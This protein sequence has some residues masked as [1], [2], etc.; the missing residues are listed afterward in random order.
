VR[1]TAA[2][3]E[4]AAL[5]GAEPGTVDELLDAATEVIC[6]TVADACVLRLADAPP[7]RHALTPGEAVLL[8]SVESGVISPGAAWTATLFGGAP[9]AAALVVPLRALGA[10]VGVMALA[11]SGASAPFDPQDVPAVRDVAD[12]LGLAVLALGLRAEGDRLRRALR[13]APG[14]RDERLDALTG[15]EREILVSIAGGL[16]SREIGVVL[17]LSV[18]TVEW[19]RA[20]LAT[21]LGTSRRSEL[22]ALGRSLHP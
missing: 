21:K 5:L 17:F 14:P 3:V 13:A 16:T 2:S 18:R 10:P 15:R 11:R 12:R 1:T 4:I 22:V 20:R 6:T 8:A 7:G 19:H 9:V